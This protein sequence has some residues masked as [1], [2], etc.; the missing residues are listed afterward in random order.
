MNKNCEIW[1]QGFSGGYETMSFVLDD[2]MSEEE[3]LAWVDS[4]DT[5]EPDA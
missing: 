5:S 3:F 2:G 1:P 4:L